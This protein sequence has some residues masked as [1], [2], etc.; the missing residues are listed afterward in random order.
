MTLVMAKVAASTIKLPGEG[1][2][3]LAKYAEV[4]ELADVGEAELPNIL[5]RV[6]VLLCWCGGEF[7]LTKW[8]RAMPNLEVIQTFSAGVDHLPYAQ[9]P[10][11]VR[12]FSNAGAYSLPVAEHA[13]SLI[14]TLAKGVH[15]RLMD[16]DRYLNDPAYSPRQL[17]GKSLLVLGTGGIGTEVA[18]IGKAAFNMR[19]MGVNRSGR[20]AAYFDETYP[21]SRLRDVLPRANVMVIALPLTKRTRGLIGEAELNLLPEDA[22]VVNV[23]RGDIVKED[24]L[25]RVLTARRGLRYGTDVFWDYGSG[26]SLNPRTGLL[27][28]PNFLGTPH[29]AGGAQPEVARRAVLMAVENAVRYLRGER[30]LNEVD[31]GDY[32]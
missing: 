28:L 24:D 30:P 5:S 26:E 20:P 31:R 29:I 21:V 25:Y 15:S 12:I 10:I 18:R 27:N 7:N 2:E 8:I 1:K 23:A 14:L 17:T 6:N 19:T 11:N 4:Y 9:I 13:W 16:R 32:V 3:L 22:I